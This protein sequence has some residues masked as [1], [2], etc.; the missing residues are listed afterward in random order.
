MSKTIKIHR[1]FTGKMHT[2]FLMVGEKFEADQAVKNVFFMA[3]RFN[4]ENNSHPPAIVPAE[5]TQAMITAFYNHLCKIMD[6][7]QGAFFAAIDAAPEH[8]DDET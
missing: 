5:P 3:E 1:I 4:P 8:P 7:H 6:D 2:A